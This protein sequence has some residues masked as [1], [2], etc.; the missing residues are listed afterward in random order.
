MPSFCGRDGA[1][2]AAVCLGAQAGILHRCTGAAGQDKVLIMAAL[3]L[4][5]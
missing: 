5:R 3:K 4:Q 1:L 2:F